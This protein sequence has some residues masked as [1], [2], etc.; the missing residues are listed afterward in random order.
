MDG[1]VLALTVFD[2]AL[3]AGGGF[4]HADGQ[5]T[6]HVAAWNGSSW[7]S[8]G[9]GIESV[10]YETVSALHVH[11]GELFVGGAFTIAGG[12][13]SPFMARWAP[14]TQGD[15]DGDRDV[16]LFDL[17]ILLSGFGIQDGASAAQGDV[18]RDGDVDLQDLAELLGT[19][20]LDCR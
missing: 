3:I 15:M 16:D 7:R 8:L 11:G 17:T 4:T 18:D 20:G 6:H 2:D 5:P 14:T 1:E 12:G 9:S 13:V 10:G 19:F